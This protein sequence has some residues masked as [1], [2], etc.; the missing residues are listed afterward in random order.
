[1]K[2]SAD[3]GKQP[4]SLFQRRE[5]PHLSFLWLL[6]YFLGEGRRELFPNTKHGY[7]LFSS[8]YWAECINM[9]TSFTSGQRNSPHCYALSPA[10]TYYQFY[11]GRWGKNPKSKLCIKGHKVLPTQA[12]GG[13]KHRINTG[14]M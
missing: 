3:C 8:V 5:P 2:F 9:L 4:H 11:R 7:H 12:T 6:M 10:E 14:Q 13:L 1:M